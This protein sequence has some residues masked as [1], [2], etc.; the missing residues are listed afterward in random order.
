VKVM[1]LAVICYCRFYSHT[2]F[3]SHA[4]TQAEFVNKGLAKQ[5][6]DARAPNRRRA[7]ANREEVVLPYSADELGA[8][9]AILQMMNDRIAGLQ[10][11][12][13]HGPNLR[14]RFYWGKGMWC[15]SI[16]VRPMDRDLSQHAICSA[17][18]RICYE[19]PQICHVSPHICYATPQLLFFAFRSH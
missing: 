15:C 6:W 4:L 11:L 18:P 7:A 19:S 12:I 9:Q 1:C 13:Q 10:L 14:L 17:S 5:P 2:H 16:C 3:P 8:A